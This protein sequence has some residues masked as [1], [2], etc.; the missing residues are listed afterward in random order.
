MIRGFKYQ[1][2]LDSPVY[3]YTGGKR[4]TGEYEK[5]KAEQSEIL[6]WA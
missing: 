4:K 2:N 3:T 6:V 5:C 1:I